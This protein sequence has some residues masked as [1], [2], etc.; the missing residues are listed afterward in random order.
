[1]AGI[2]LNI[3]GSTNA[4][5]E[6]SIPVAPIVQEVV[7]IPLAPPS[8]E[9]YDVKPELERVWQETISKRAGRIDIAVFNNAT[10]NISHAGNSEGNP[11]KTASI[12]KLAILER[13]LMVDPVWA[14]ENESYI[15]PMIT[16]SDNGIATALWTKVGGTESMQEFFNQ[17]GAPGTIASGGGGLFN[18]MTTAVDQ[19]M[20]AKA[21]AYPNPLRPEDVEFTKNLLHQVVPDQRWGISGGVP[22][23]VLVESKNGWVDERR[24]SIGHVS[25][26]GVDYTIAVL[27]DDGPGAAY[28]MDTIEQLSA[29]TWQIMRAAA[30]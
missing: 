25:G 24:N 17:V 30:A 26:Q 9:I 20:V 13:L 5:A 2:A 22:G 16:Q 21:A 12:I 19:V 18:T 3:S 4:E 11:F 6:P 28:D 7:P 8:P 29:A 10:G 1:M 27:T 15:R 23:D 14:R